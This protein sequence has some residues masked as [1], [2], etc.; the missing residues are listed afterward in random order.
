MCGKKQGSEDVTVWEAEEGLLR[1]E[2][3][4]DDDWGQW[5]GAE[6]SDDESDKGMDEDEYPYFSD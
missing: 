6:W 5:H 1:S 3:Y 4:Q 2:I